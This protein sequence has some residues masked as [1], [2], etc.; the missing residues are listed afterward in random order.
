[1]NFERKTALIHKIHA[2]ISMAI[3]FFVF[4]VLYSIEENDYS[5]AAGIIVILLLLLLFGTAKILYDMHIND[6]SKRSLIFTY[7]CVLLLSC[8]M[9]YALYENTSLFFML[10]A[11]SVVIAEILVAVLICY[12]FQILKSLKSIIKR[13]K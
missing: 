11:L 8:M 4:S 9:T 10:I 12:R 7:I 2:W 13:S 3:N 5:K 1:M 6:I